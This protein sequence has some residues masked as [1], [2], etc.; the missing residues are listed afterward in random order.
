[1][2]AAAASAAS[3]APADAAADRPFDRCS[4]ILPRRPSLTHVLRVRPQFTR[5]SG[6][7]VRVVGFTTLGLGSGSY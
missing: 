1:M 4:R 2:T 5:S 7:G 3:A 6:Y